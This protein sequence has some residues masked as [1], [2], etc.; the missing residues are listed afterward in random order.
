[1][2]SILIPIYNISCSDLVEDLVVQCDEINIPY[3]IICMDDGSLQPYKNSN[4]KIYDLSNVQYIELEEN[5]GRARIRNLLATKSQYQYLLFIDADSGIIRNDFITK[6]ISNL[7]DDVIYG[8]TNY[9]ISMPIDKDYLLHWKYASRYEALDYSKRNAK[10]YLAFMSNNFLINK[11]IF[12]KI[13]FEDSHTGYGYEDTLFAEKLHNLSIEIHHIDNPVEHTGLSKTETFIQKTEEAMR[14]LA[15]MLNNNSFPETH[16]VS[17]HKKMKSFGLEVFLIFIFR[18]FKS[19]ILKN[20]RSE[21]PYLFC[22]QFY[23]YG[24]FCISLKNI[25]SD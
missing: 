20:L 24:I 5:I 11:D 19:L 10:P 22:F 1:M 18:M 14:N 25:K 7:K 2:L 15:R 6:Y 8:G 23:K 9:S 16:M 21:N 3:E 4:R 12:N 17:F 13:K